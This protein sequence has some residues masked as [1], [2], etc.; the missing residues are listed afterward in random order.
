[1]PFF[2]DKNGKNSYK[3]SKKTLQNTIFLV[4]I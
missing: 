2:D 1:M 3:I 4:I